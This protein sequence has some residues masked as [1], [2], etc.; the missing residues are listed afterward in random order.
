MFKSLLNKPTWINIE[1]FRRGSQR[2]SIVLSCSGLA[3]GSFIPTERV[4]SEQKQH[5]HFMY[6][7]LYMSIFLLKQLS[8]K[9]GILILFTILKAVI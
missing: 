7:T 9:G 8:N 4:E 6:N 1:A 5:N 3:S 2:N